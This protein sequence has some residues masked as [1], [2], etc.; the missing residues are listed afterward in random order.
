MFASIVLG[1]FL[2]SETGDD[3]SCTCKNLGDDS[4]AEV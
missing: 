2:E 1:Q 3:V 4:H